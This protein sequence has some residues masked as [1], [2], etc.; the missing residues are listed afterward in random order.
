[1]YVIAEAGVNHNGSCALAHQLVDA[2]AEAGAQAIKFQ[3][4]KTQNLVTSTAKRAPYQ[5]QQLGL[6]TQAQMLSALELPFAA[7]CDL[8]SHAQ[9]C[10]LDFISTPFDQ[11]SAQFL[12]DLGVETLKIGSGDLDNLPLLLQA[13]QAQCQIILSSGMSTLGEIETALGAIAFGVNKAK[14]KPSLAAFHAH[15]AQSDLSTRVS[16]LHCTSDYPAKAETLNLRAIPTL[17][18]AFGLRTGFS[19][20][21]KGADAALI[22]LTLGA[23]ILE[24]HL[25]LDCAMQ[26]PDH[27]ASLDPEAFKVM[28]LRLKQAKLALGTGFKKPMSNELLTRQVARKRVVAACDIAQNSLFTLEN[29]TLKRAC[30]G[31]EASQIFAFMGQKAAKNYATDE[32]VLP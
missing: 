1:M 28:V 27:A 2:A 10:G 24:K 3:T 8:K 6:G 14:E 4:F 22:A 5:I 19:D 30:E 21:S 25:T 20:H 13:G 16:L 31:A 15:Y 11:E 12:L 7:F 9:S 17:K 29:L 32:G 26:G 23:E 18:Q